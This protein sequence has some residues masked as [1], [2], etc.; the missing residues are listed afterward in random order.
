[1][2]FISGWTKRAPITVNPAY[3]SAGGVTDF[4]MLVPVTVADDIIAGLA[5]TDGRD[6]RFCDPSTLA[7]YSHELVAIDTVAKTIQAW[8]KVPSILSSGP[9]IIDMQFGNPTAPMPSAAE[10][11]ATWSEYGGVWHLDEASGVLYDATGN[12]NN[13]I[14]MGGTYGVTTPIGKGVGFTGG[15]G[16]PRA[17]FADSA[18]LATPDGLGLG[19]WVYC[20]SAADRIGIL[21]NNNPADTAG[22]TLFRFGTGSANAYF[23]VFDKNYAVMALPASGWHHVF[24]Y[25]DNTTMRLYVDGVPGADRSASGAIPDA[26]REL[27]FGIGGDPASSQWQSGNHQMDQVSYGPPRAA[28]WITTEYNNQSA[29]GTFAAYGPVETLATGG[30]SIIGSSIVRPSIVIPRRW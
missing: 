10:Q 18:S 3:V 6:I 29:P 7:V 26:G 5:F 28:A 11:Q 1:M 8:V 16:G 25:Y 22:W 30:G 12:A 24:A 9:T 14:Y 19:V 15:G 13:S 27:R 17:D 23:Q 21:T 2:G 20:N 4:R